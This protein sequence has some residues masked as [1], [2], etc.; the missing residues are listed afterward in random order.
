MKLHTII[1]LQISLL[2]GMAPDAR[3]LLHSRI[4]QLCAEYDATTYGE[5]AEILQL[6]IAIDHAIK[7]KQGVRS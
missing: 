3:S 1:D 5:Q 7:L 4:E 6:A 2:P